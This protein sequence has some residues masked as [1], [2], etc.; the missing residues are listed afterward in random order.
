LFLCLALLSVFYYWF[1]HGFLAF[2]FQPISTSRFFLKAFAWFSSHFGF[3]RSLLC[4]VITFRFQPISTLHF[5][6]WLLLDFL[7]FWFHPIST[8]RFFLW[9]SFAFLTFWFQP[10]STLRCFYHCCSFSFP[11]F[12][13]IVTFR[14]FLFFRMVSSLF[15]F[16]R[17]RLC[18][19]F[20]R[21]S[22][23]FLSFWF[24]PISTLFFVTFRFQPISTLRLFHKAF[25]WF[26]LILVSADH[27]FV[28]YY[29]P[30]SDDLYFAFFS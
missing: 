15:N 27:Y 16:S 12:Q 26:P 14:F 24:Q 18:I 11:F 23:G 9:L 1:S 17:S 25:E 22:L 20:L 10:I 28:S 6:L 5:L 13:P 29:F 3:S 21:P 19:F 8:L 30:V 7:A 4:F 2:Q